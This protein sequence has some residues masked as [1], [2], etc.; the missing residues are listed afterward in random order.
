MRRFLV[1]TVVLLILSPLSSSF[2]GESTQTTLDAAKLSRDIDREVPAATQ[3]CADA[4][5]IQRLKLQ[6]GDELFSTATK[7]AQYASS[8]GINSLPIYNALDNAGFTID[9]NVEIYALEQS[10]CYGG[11]SWLPSILARLSDFASESQNVIIQIEAQKEIIRAAFLSQNLGQPT[12]GGL[13]A[14]LDAVTNI[15]IEASNLLSLISLVETESSQLNAD[16]KMDMNSATAKPT[17]KPTAKLTLKMPPQNIIARY[18]TVGATIFW[19]AP[20]SGIVTK[21]QIRISLNGSAF[22]LLATIPATRLS[23]N[24][25]KHGPSGWSTFLIS[26]VYSDG[27]AVSAKAFGLPGQYS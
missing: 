15:N 4:A 11:N 12:Y 13:D 6:T 27:T 17:A 23:E 10:S 7:L 9:Q 21:Y 14:Y 20:S 25:I 1:L 22:R 19:G 8:M 2:A 3:L 16:R 24:V 26:V 18:T 5:N